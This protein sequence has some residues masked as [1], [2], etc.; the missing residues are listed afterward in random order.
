MDGLQLYDFSRKD[1]PFVGLNRLKVETC[2]LCPFLAFGKY[3]T[4]TNPDASALDFG[5]EMKG[6]QHSQR[7]EVI[8]VG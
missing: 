8:L 4:S 5:A 6:S 2:G 7:D 3:S 1:T